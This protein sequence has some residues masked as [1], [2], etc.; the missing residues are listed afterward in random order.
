M[1]AHRRAQR[2]NISCNQADKQYCRNLVTRYSPAPTT[3]CKRVIEGGHIREGA[4]RC[5]CPVL[6]RL[7]DYF[8]SDVRESKKTETTAIIT[9]LVAYRRARRSNK[10]SCNKPNELSCHNLV[11]SCWPM[12]SGGPRPIKGRCTFEGVT[13]GQCL[14]HARLPDYFLSD[15][16]ESKKTETTTVATVLP[17]YR[18]ARRSNK[19]SCNRPNEHPLCN[20]V[21]RCLPTAAGG[22]RP[23]E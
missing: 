11:T 23:I 10:S 3:C 7:P 12:P 13:G 5:H 8:L 19:S 18:R 2:S 16:R 17:A 21:A 4:T 15:V 1:T 22:L 6:A 9:D 20:V 14:V